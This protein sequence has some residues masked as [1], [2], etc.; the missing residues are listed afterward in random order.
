MSSRRPHVWIPEGFGSAKDGGPTRLSK[1]EALIIAQRAAAED[2]LC[3]DLA[4]V[5]VQGRAG[6]PVWIVSSATVG[7]VLEVSI[8]DASGAVL[9]V[10]RIGVR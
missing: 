5:A 2:P 1:E 4:M 10:R 3:K 7:L 9:A 8:D 6:T